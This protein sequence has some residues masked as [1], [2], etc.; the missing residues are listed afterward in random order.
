MALAIPQKTP[1]TIKRGMSGAAAYA[2][3][4][5]L[6]SR[7]YRLSEDG[8]FG[9]LTKAAVISWQGA[10][11]L[12]ADGLFGPASSSRMADVLLDTVPTPLPQGLGEGFVYAESGELI[13]AV[14]RS[15][16]GGVDC[17]YTQRRVL[18]AD[19]GDD[20]VIRRAFDSRYQ[21][22]LLARTVAERRAAYRYRTGVASPTVLAYI[23]TP[24]E[25]AW[26]LAA[27]HH[28]WPYA[29]ET[30]SKGGRLSDKTATWAPVGLTFPDGHPVRTYW[31]WA[32]F[33]ALGA[34]E[35]GHPGLV[36]ARV[37]SW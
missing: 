27:L 17:G 21:L 6:N 12:L 34:P 10:T 36:T 30:L 19:Y 37:Q 33:Y 11:G 4:R 35:H 5:A 24:E 13:A 23:P 16:A 20:A 28:N 15:V 32:Q 14:N 25:R 18:E 22:A 2:V 1:Y 3:Q 31:E 26:R 7:G 8:V 29:A 9:Q